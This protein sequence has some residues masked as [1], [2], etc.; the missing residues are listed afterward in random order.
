MSLPTMRHLNKERDRK[1]SDGSDVSEGGLCAKLSSQ[2]TTVD[3]KA[4]ISEMENK[5]LD[6]LA[7]IKT[8]KVKQDYQDDVILEGIARQVEALG[9]KVSNLEIEERERVT[10]L[11]QSKMTWDTIKKTDRCNIEEKRS[12]LQSLKK[13]KTLLDI[14]VTDVKGEM[15]QANA[16]NEAET[17][18]RSNE[19]G[20]IEKSIEIIADSIEIQEKEVSCLQKDFNKLQSD[21]KVRI[22]ENEQK[23]RELTT[24]R[25][26]CQDK[27]ADLKMTKKELSDKID[28]LKLAHLDENSEWLVKIEDLNKTIEELNDS[29]SINVEKCVELKQIYDELEQKQRAEDEENDTKQAELVAIKIECL[30]KKMELEQLTEQIYDDIEVLKV[31]NLAEKADEKTK[32]DK[33]RNEISE[34]KKSI[35]NKEGEIEWLRIAHDE[36]QQDHIRLVKL[37][38]KISK[39]MELEVKHLADQQKDKEDLEQSLQDQKR[40]LQNLIQ[41]TNSGL[42]QLQQTS[43]LQEQQRTSSALIVANLESS[44]EESRNT[45]SDLLKQL[46][47]LARQNKDVDNRIVD[48]TEEYTWVSYELEEELRQS[49]SRIGDIEEE[50]WRNEAELRDKT[51]R[52][53]N[54]EDDLEKKRRQTNELR[55]KRK[56]ILPS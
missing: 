28:Y 51:E 23:I 42:E 16:K 8:V 46:K 13:R 38:Y 47:D 2:T 19:I 34:L 20:S 11:A 36:L 29:I 52:M 27:D 5:L 54:L 25:D 30:N 14:K 53:S 10:N 4:R 15:A 32:I 45:E 43:D 55:L 17:E 56:S 40:D 9:A 3:S 1:C 33:L 50:V 6:M 35:G 48:L 39:D 21:Y 7:N 41:K 12:R 22:F 31:D 24:K 44:L 18:I 49:G 37:N 26:Q